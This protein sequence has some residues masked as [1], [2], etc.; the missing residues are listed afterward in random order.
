MLWKALTE[1]N[2]LGMLI[3]SCRIMC[4]TCRWKREKFHGYLST[5]S[6]EA[7]GQWGE[8]ARLL[9][10]EGKES[11]VNSPIGIFFFK[12]NL[13]NTE[14]EKHCWQDVCCSVFPSNLWM[15]RFIGKG[16]AWGTV[17]DSVIVHT[18]L[19][20]PWKKKNHWV[21][22]KAGRRTTLMSKHLLVTGSSVHLFVNLF[23][24]I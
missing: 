20:T 9:K 5:A 24:H 13:V 15:G 4:A 23:L 21:V 3:S 16:L 7:G 18:F 2:S 14:L 6:T 10:Q 12:E 22:N 19:K 1:C 17:I 11:K 8:P